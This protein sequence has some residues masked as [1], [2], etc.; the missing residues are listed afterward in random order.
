M[1]YFNS[2]IKR[3]FAQLNFWENKKGMELDQSVKEVLRRTR[4]PE[5]DLAHARIGRHGRKSV[6]CVVVIRRFAVS[7]TI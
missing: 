6:K 2:F 1:S 3:T 4:Q 5:R 7:L